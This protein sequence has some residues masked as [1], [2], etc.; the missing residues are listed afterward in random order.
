VLPFVLTE[1]YALGAY[2]AL[3]K[4]YP[5]EI[6]AIHF[7]RKFPPYTSAGYTL[8]NAGWRVAQQ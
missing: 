6:S 7:R 3:S 4:V 5:A 1:V 8:L 2:P